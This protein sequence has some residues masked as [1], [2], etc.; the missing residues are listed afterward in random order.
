[1]PW[2]S[3]QRE[4]VV[5]QASIGDSPKIH[6]SKYKSW[7]NMAFF[8][9]FDIV[10]QDGT[11]PWWIRS[12][13]IFTWRYKCKFCMTLQTFRRRSLDVL[14]QV[15]N[16][17]EEPMDTE[18]LL[19]LPTQ[20]KPEPEPMQ[21]SPSDSWGPHCWWISTVRTKWCLSLVDRVPNLEQNEDMHVLKFN[22]HAIHQL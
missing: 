11:T 18:I 10:L 2:I 5:L 3:S 17:P 13:N 9:H 6:A 21:A 8:H 19:N 14:L 16:L 12:W 15:T 20:W 1:M 22:Y 7:P 4:T